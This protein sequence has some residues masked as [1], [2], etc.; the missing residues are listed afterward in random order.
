MYIICMYEYLI[1]YLQ[2]QQD[3]T[4][5]DDHDDKMIPSITE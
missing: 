1:A 2:K 3:N 4:T 5:K